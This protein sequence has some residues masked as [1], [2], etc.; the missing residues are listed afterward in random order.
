[1]GWRSWT[2]RAD[3]VG[4]G[5]TRIVMGRR[6]PKPHRGR[7]DPVRAWTRATAG[8]GREPD[9]RMSLFRHADYCNW[10]SHDP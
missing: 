8:A 7:T 6:E 2:G 10:S 5:R 3:I 4:S 9:L 1:M